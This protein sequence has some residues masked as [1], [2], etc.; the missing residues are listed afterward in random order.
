[1]SAILAGAVGF[2][3]LR[4]SFHFI[5]RISNSIDIATARAVCLSSGIKQPFAYPQHTT[6]EVRKLFDALDGIE[7]NLA[8]GSGLTPVEEA[9]VVIDPTLEHEESEK[10]PTQDLTP[11][12]EVTFPEASIPF[13]LPLFIRQIVDSGRQRA[14]QRKIDLQVIFGDNVP[15]HIVGKPEGLYQGLTALLKNAFTLTQGGAI[16]VRISRI[17]DMVGIML[18]RFEVADSGT[19]IPWKEQPELENRLRQAAAADPKKLREPILRAAAI[20]RQLGGELGFE[21]QPGSG[22]RF[23]FTA[24]FEPTQAPVAT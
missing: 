12:P 17:P 9:P 13:E 10:H 5:H 3:T 2:L 11:T 14:M 1:L 15:S 16:V 8:S 7:T 20:A 24:C 4:L 19:G 21:S 18:L 22:S 23:W 6:H